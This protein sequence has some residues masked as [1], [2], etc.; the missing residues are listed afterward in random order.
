MSNEDKIT[1]EAFDTLFQNA[2][3]HFDLHASAY[4]KYI[5]DLSRLRAV[6]IVGSTDASQSQGS[7]EQKTLQAMSRPRLRKLI[8]SRQ[9]SAITALQ[10]RLARVTQDQVKTDRDAAMTSLRFIVDSETPTSA[11]TAD[12]FLKQ[13]DTLIKTKATLGNEASAVVGGM[14]LPT[15]MYRANKLGMTNPANASSDGYSEARQ[16]LDAEYSDQMRGIARTALR[17]LE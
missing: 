4:E 11:A 17:K 9:E 13:V 14:S 12:T 10:S 1:F 16:T 2:P 5:N 6:V 15:L 7:T 8:T 3:P